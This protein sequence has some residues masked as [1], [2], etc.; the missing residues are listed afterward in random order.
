MARILAGCLASFGVVEALG[1]GR[2]NVVR[3]AFHQFVCWPR[4]AGN[5]GLSGLVSALMHLAEL[6]SRNGSRAQPCRAHFSHPACV[7]QHVV[8]V[9]RH[10]NN[11]GIRLRNSVLD[12]DAM[13]LAIG[14]IGISRAKVYA[15]AAHNRPDWERDLNLHVSR[16]TPLKSASV[17]D[18]FRTLAVLVFIALA[19]LPSLARALEPSI[20]VARIR[21]FV[22]AQMRADAIPGLAI[23]VVTR[24]GISYAEGFG[25]NP[26]DAKAIT[27]DTPFLLGSMSKSVT[28]LAV[29]QLVES[30][31]IVI[32]APVLSY[33]PNFAMASAQAEQIT[34]RE[35]LAHTSGIPVNAARAN[36]DAATLADHVA[37]LRGVRLERAPG[38]AYEYASPNYQI[39]GRIV[40]VVSGESFGTYVAR[41]IFKPLGMRHS[42]VD[43]ASA[44]DAGLAQGHQ[45]MFGF[46]VARPLP[47]EPGRLPTAA[48]IAS[49]NDL[50]RY[51]RMQLRGGELDGARVVSESGVTAMHQP[52]VQ[53]DGFGYAMGWR[54]S[55]IGGSNAVHHGGILPNYR[56]KMVLLPERD[57]GVVVLTNVSTAIG[58]PSSHRIADGVAAI[59]AG[60]EPAPSPAWPLRGVL[61]GMAIGMLMITALQLRALVKAARAPRSLP[62]AARELVFALAILFGL[63]WWG[64]VGWTGIYTQAPDLAAWAILA[65]AL[66]LA[67]G[68]LRIRGS[69]APG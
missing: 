50:G 48:L 38:S 63:P 15:T 69:R 29:M 39:L 10:R 35:L 19:A 65:A 16:G 60:Q 49:A 61:L 51:L 3:M 45:M 59:A 58:S 64:G 1:L 17:L 8:R 62:R 11:G 66:G 9:F 25:T 28:A 44:L 23:V 4:Y 7:G 2:C 13:E 26:S 27:A 68:L 30:G 57:I 24:D 18:A 37:A 53:L 55:E 36:N 14:Y 52:L 54:V 6:A 46:A 12:L 40:E 34:V 41:H 47:A 22:S 5:A 31:R 67:T 43:Y 20:D 32:D 21:Q 33:L 56:G 42:Y